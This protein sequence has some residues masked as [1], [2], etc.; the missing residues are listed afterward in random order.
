MKN[1]VETALED[2]RFSMLVT[3]IRAADLEDMLTSPGP[4]TVFA[5]TDSAFRGIPET[6]LKDILD[7]RQKIGALLSYHIVPEKLTANDLMGRRIVVS[8]QGGELRIKA[9][10]DQVMVNDAHVVAADIECTN[11][12]CHAIDTV[13]LPRRTETI[14]PG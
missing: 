12:I 9:S 7:D 2:V 3:A 4:F 8:L 11:G 13:L 1:I 5:P 10:A 14:L 6:L